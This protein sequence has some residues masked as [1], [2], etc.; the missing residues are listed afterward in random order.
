MHLDSFVEDENLKLT[1]TKQNALTR[2]PTEKGSIVQTGTP[3]PFDDVSSQQTDTIDIKD[4]LQ[5]EELRRGK[6]RSCKYWYHRPHD[7]TETSHP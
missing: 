4:D 2:V 5:F 6:R 1:N 7:P 3:E